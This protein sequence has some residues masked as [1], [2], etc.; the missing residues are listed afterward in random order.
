MSKN[1]VKPIVIG[2]PKVSKVARPYNE[3][4]TGSTLNSIISSISKIR[5]TNS[6][7]TF[8]NNNRIGKTSGIPPPKKASA[9]KT[10][11][12]PPPKTPS[13]TPTTSKTPSKP[14]VTPSTTPTTS[15]TPSK[16]S[17]T[18]SATT[19]SKTPSKPSVTTTSKPLPNTPSSG[20]IPEKKSKVSFR[21]KIPNINTEKEKLKLDIDIP[22]SPRRA[23]KT[24]FSGQRIELPQDR[25]SIN[26]VDIPA[27]ADTQSDAKLLKFTNIQNKALDEIDNIDTLSL[28]PNSPSSRKD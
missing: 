20:S 24:P 17:V 8:Q 1:Q 19:A 9:L 18:P 11:S 7:A 3:E 25:T 13:A 23:E 14:S 21:K 26:K 16:P 4:N 5:P 6:K 12:K 28:V 15:K 22:T 10:P 27:Y 2:R